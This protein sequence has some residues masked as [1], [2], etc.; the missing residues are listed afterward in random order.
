MTDESLDL[1]ALEEH[2]RELPPYE[3][4]SLDPSIVLRLIALART[5]VPEG[6]KPIER[7]PRDGTPILA[8]SVNH[9]AREVVCWQDGLDSGSFE[10]LIADEPEPEKGWVNNGPIKDRFYANPRWF[11]H[12]QPLPAPPATSDAP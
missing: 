11:T 4:A 12:W 6:W 1:D 8:C 10:N 9:D 5:S 3:D 2:V 7:A